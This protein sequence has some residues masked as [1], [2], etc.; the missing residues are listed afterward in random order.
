MVVNVSSPLPLDKI[1]E[2][3]A[4]EALVGREYTGQSA[5]ESCY[6]RLSSP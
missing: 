2:H 4:L 1:P 6:S 5:L 3:A